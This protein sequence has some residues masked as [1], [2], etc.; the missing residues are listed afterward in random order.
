[1]VSFATETFLKAFKDSAFFIE[2]SKQPIRVYSQQNAESKKP[3]L[4]GEQ[5]SSARRCL[6]SQLIVL[7]LS[8]IE[9]MLMKKNVVF[10]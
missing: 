7:D 3:Y 5:K 4:E 9:T 8:Q 6:N 2:P 10:A 1:M